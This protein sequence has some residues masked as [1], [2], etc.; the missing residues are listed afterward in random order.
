MLR[1]DRPFY[2][3]LSLKLEFLDIFH[4]R[5]AVIIFDVALDIYFLT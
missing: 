1:K 2:V 4:A 3:N 5:I